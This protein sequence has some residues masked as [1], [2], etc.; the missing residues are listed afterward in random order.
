MNGETWALLSAYAS[1]L[2][3]LGQ[4]K[5]AQHLTLVL[6]PLE[7]PGR[8][9]SEAMSALE[10]RGLIDGSRLT[11]QGLQIAEGMAKAADL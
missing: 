6:Y 3:S 8:D 7:P 9:L 2:N 11:L 5:E 1:F 10:G 4:R